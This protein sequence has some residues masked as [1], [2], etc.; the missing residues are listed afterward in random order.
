MQSSFKSKSQNVLLKNTWVSSE[1]EIYL[2]DFQPPILKSKNKPP[3]KIFLYFSR[4]NKFSTH[5]GMT[6]DQ[7]MK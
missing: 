4:K 1:F 6:A 7:A 3:K 2:V 5:F